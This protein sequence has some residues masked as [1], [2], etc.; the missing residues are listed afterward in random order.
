MKYERFRS[1]MTLVP[2]VATAVIYFATPW[3]LA[4]ERVSAAPMPMAAHSDYTDCAAAHPALPAPAR[5]GDG[6]GRSQ[7]PAW[8]QQHAAAIEACLRQASTT[9]YAAR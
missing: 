8:Q 6:Q 2:V 9:H 1:V 7:W 5:A 3:L 4:R